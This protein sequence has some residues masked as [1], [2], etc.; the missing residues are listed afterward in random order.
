[1]G[2]KVMPIPSP[3]DFR[4]RTKKHSQVREM[5]ARMAESA[6]GIDLVNAN[7]LFK[8]KMLTNTDG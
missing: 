4:D 1:M 6:V 5:M 7:P 3:A 2:V 8:S